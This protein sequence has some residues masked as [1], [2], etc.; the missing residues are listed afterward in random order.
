MV[1][2][3]DIIIMERGLISLTK[4]YTQKARERLPGL[5]MVSDSLLSSLRSREY[6]ASA[7]RHTSV[8][9]VLIPCNTYLGV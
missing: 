4:V 3:R 7:S 6:S 9:S 2:F 1:E 5:S 8:F